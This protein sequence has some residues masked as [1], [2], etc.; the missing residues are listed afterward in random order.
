LKLSNVLWQ[1]LG[2]RS[3]RRLDLKMLNSVQ[4]PR[5]KCAL[6]I[7]VLAVLVLSVVGLLLLEILLQ[8]I[9]YFK[10]GY[11]LF[12][13]QN[14]ISVDYVKSVADRRQYSLKD[15]V[16]TDRY[17]INSSGFRGPKKSEHDNRPVICIL[18]DSV[19]FGWGVRDDETFP[20]LLQQDL[21]DNGYHYFVLNAG[22]PSYN[23]RQSLD[24][25][26]LD[27]APTYRCSVIVLN[28][29][30]DVSL[31]D[32]YG[33]H[34]SPDLTWASER[35]GVKAAQTSAAVFFAR[36][37]VRRLGELL[38]AHPRGADDAVSMIAADVV[39]GLEPALAEGTRVVIVPVN[40]CFYW[41][42]AGNDRDAGACS[43]YA[44]YRQLADRWRPIIDKINA[45]L[46]E[47]SRQKGL[48]YFDAVAEF[49]A[50]GREAAFVDFMHY[51]KRGNKLIADKLYE[52]FA[53]DGYVKRTGHAAPMGGSR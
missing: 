2:P 14:T 33:S 31:I 9:F 36:Q 30:N 38:E 37:A 50:A 4:S 12:T 43:G 42:R 24:R 13:G 3:F 29:A 41:D 48:Y 23:L 10:N 44:D 15:G 40:G 47:V 19:M 52:V 21:D 46:R 7:P 45:M 11:W 20:A 18:G 26:R 32:Y 28:A 6:A 35:F 51:S 25:W 27:V 22:V 8:A 53:R 49:D 34:W 5:Q 16:F 17:T 1:N 39:R